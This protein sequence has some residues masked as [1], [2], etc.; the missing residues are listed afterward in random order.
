MTATSFALAVLL[1]DNAIYKRTVL[2]QQH[3]LRVYDDSPN[4]EMRFLARVNGFTPLRQLIELAPA[5]ARDCISVV[6]RLV[7]RGLVELL[8]P[9]A[10]T[11]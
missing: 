6:P 7:D 11:D 8:D 2:G 10:A 4:V 1:D 5:D 3:L 9:K